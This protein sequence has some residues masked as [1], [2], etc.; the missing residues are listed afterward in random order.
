MLLH[1]SWTSSSM[2]SEIL[3]QPAHHGYSAF[4]ID[5]PNHGESFATD[6]GELRDI[7]CL[8]MEAL[9]A[10]GL[11]AHFSVVLSHCL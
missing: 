7:A 8:V 9:D 5:L 4:A 10:I 6:K 1:S 3:L 2:F 11:P